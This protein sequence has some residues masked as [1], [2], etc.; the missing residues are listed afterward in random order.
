MAAGIASLVTEP[1]QAISTLVTSAE[2]RSLAWQQI[3]GMSGED[4]LRAVVEGQTEAFRDV[5]QGIVCDDGYLLGR[6]LGGI[7]IQLTGAKLAKPSPATARLG[8]ANLSRLPLPRPKMPAAIPPA[9]RE[10]VENF[11]RRDVMN[12]SMQKVRV[13]S[14]AID[15]RTGKV[16]WSRISGMSDDRVEQ[17]ALADLADKMFPYPE[18]RPL[19]RSPALCAEGGGCFKRLSEGVD[20]KSLEVD[21]FTWEITTGL[22]VERCANCQIT[23]N[24]EGQTI[25]SESPYEMYTMDQIKDIR[26]QQKGGGSTP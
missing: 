7:A 25:Y 21:T 18:V 15:R 19:S 12:A 11:Y 5:Y 8:M 20:V 3:Q 17:K 10:A 24:W 6:G 9:L 16:V 22:P 14:V 2:A 26:Q 4:L 13:A 23:V 1:V